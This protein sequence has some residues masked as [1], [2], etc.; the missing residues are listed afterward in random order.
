MQG[1]PAACDC[2]RHGRLPAIILGGPAPRRKWT[3]GDGGG[4]VC[5]SPG[6]HN[7]DDLLLIDGLAARYITNGRR[8]LSDCARAFVSMQGVYE[9]QVQ[10]RPASQNKYV[11]PR[12]RAIT[13]TRSRKAGRPSGQ[14][15]NA[16]YH[17]SQFGWLLEFGAAGQQSAQP[18]RS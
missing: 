11:G 12:S 3:R 4:G 8:Q 6:W 2:I 9:R 14:S 15:Q 10:R 5:I 16:V 1:R 7:D 17:A 13:N 18:G